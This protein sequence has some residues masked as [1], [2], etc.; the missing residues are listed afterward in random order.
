[1][2]KIITLFVIILLSASAISAQSSRDKKAV[3]GKW[4]FDAPYAPEGYTSGTIELSFAENKYSTSISF[5]G[6]DY[7]IPG[8][9]TK[10]E[11]DSV[12][13][14]VYVE[15]E[16]VEIFLKQENESK[17]AGKATYSQGEIPLTLTKE[18]PKK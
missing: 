5:T 8:E 4:K 18:V 11:N 3:T 12:T 15:S 14:V 9:K 13:F 1:M 6:S 7:K 2:R 10:V 17:M 16:Q